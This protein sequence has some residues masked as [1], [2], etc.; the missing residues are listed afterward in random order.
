M[1]VYL[2]RL[3]VLA[4]DKAVADGVKIHAKRL[5]R[6]VLVFLADNVNGIVGKGNVLGRKVCEVRLLFGLA[7]GILRGNVVSL[8]ARQHALQDHKKAHAAC[9]HHAGLFE[10]RV[11]VDGILKRDLRGLN[12]A[13][14]Y[15]LEICILRGELSG[16]VRSQAGDGQDRSLRGLHDSLIGGLHACGQSIRK[17]LAACFQ[18][19]L[20]GLG[21][22]PE[23]KR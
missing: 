15:A 1:D 18:F 13:C 5:K 7:G 21:K 17:V 2:E 20:E 12:G 22:A 10:D 6:N 8:K 4:D 14:Q 19:S 3:V 11:L 16:S 23:Q 9:V